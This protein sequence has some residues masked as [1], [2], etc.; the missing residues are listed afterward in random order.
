[1]W[2][3]GARSSQVV[4][5]NGVDVFLAN[6][7]ANDIAILSAAM[8]DT[9]SAILKVDTSRGIVETSNR[10]LRAIIGAPRDTFLSLMTGSQ[11]DLAT[12]SRHQA[13]TLLGKSSFQW[14]PTNLH[15]AREACDCQSWLL[16]VCMSAD[17]VKALPSNWRY[18]VRMVH[19]VNSAWDGET[20]IGTI[21]NLMEKWRAR[22]NRRWGPAPRPVP[23]PAP[24]AQ[25][26]AGGAQ[27]P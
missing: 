25:P 20:I 19:G 12:L 14:D 22:L 2:G 17:D 8:R 9:L 18:R 23:P 27:P 10:L 11:P 21:F 26:Q 13:D 3:Y 7:I 5:G 6:I 1:M 24:Q 4:C 16:G 15:E